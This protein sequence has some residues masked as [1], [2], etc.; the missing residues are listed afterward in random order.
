MIGYVHGVVTYMEADS[1]IVDVQGV[2][3]RLLIPTSTGEKIAKGEEYTLFTHLQVREDSWVL[4]GFYTNE[5]YE[6][7][8]LLLTVAGIGPK[9]A[10]GIL[11]AIRPDGFYH[12]IR[13][14]NKSVLTSLPGIGKKTADR[15]LLELKDKVEQ[16]FP[17]E[18]EF[19]EPE[20]I[21]EADGIAME[22]LRALVGLG[23]TEREVR[24]TVLRLAAS[25][26]ETGTLLRAV[27]NELGKERR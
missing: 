1:C 19:D 17:V 14:K 11:S 15:L 23:Y 25:H 22:T 4:Y 13:T 16:Y 10:C 2:G 20:V 12:A 24:K 18:E 9:V 7:F 27:L 6:L 3:Y 21:E 26:D 8:T 5:E